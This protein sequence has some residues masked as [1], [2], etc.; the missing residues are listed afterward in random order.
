MECFINA[1]AGGHRI[2]EVKAGGRG[3]CRSG[4]IFLLSLA[5]G[6]LATFFDHVHKARH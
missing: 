6:F 1:G 4:D 2:R 5:L 3:E